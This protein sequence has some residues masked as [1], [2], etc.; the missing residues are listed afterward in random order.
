MA[1]AWIYNMAERLSD[2][3]ETWAHG[4]IYR[5]ARYPAH[6][7]RNA[8]R[9]SD[10]PGRSPEELRDFTE[11]RLAGLAHRRI[12]F[13]SAV[14]AEPYRDYF[15]RCGYLTLRLTWMHFEAE[16]PGA[17]DPRVREVE[18]GAVRALREAWQREDFPDTDPTAY[19]DQSEAIKTSLGAR[20]LAVYDG[21]A[22]VAFAGL[23]PD[24]DEL[25]IGA[26]YVLPEH[27]GRG[28]GTTLAQ[29][30][31]AV[32]GVEHVWICADDEDRP[33]HLYRRL[34]FRPVRTT[35]MFLRPPRATD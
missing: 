2:T 23:D 28:L 22:P 7:D 32:A 26:L 11:E 4:T 15:R 30:A 19:L 5:S 33:K 29:S 3:Q 35:A 12:S 13:D 14:L 24:G 34:G 27:R 16:R 25:E 17:P 1:L 6:S 10:D 9:V 31:L 8:V 18:Y 21:S 20:T